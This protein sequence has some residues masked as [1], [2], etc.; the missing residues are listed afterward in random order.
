MQIVFLA[1]GTS[2]L[3]AQYEAKGI[4]LKKQQQQY[5]QRRFLGFSFALRC[6]HME[7]VD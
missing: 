3:S 6:N 5:L 4:P 7:A 1:D 2:S